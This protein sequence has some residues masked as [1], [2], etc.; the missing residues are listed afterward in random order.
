MNIDFTNDIKRSKEK[1]V[2]NKP[3]PTAS[4]GYAL[5]AKNE[6]GNFIK[7]I[8]SE[9]DHIKKYLNDAGYDWGNEGKDEFRNF[10]SLNRLLTVMPELSDVET[11]AADPQWAIL[12]KPVDFPQNSSKRD[13]ED[14]PEA[15]ELREVDHPIGYDERTHASKED[16]GKNY[17]ELWK[18][19]NSED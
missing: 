11:V 6:D 19:V 9:Q 16:E 18:K 5:F 4:G 17:S 2:L 14:V 8:F 7:M 3:F 12:E 15:V 1:E 10:D 13:M